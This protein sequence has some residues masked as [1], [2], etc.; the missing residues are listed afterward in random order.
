M[1][2]HCLTD[3]ECGQK[4]SNGIQAMNKKI[5]TIPITLCLFAMAFT[6]FLCF[7]VDSYVRSARVQCGNVG[8]SYDSENGVCAVRKKIP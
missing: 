7:Y 6:T 5:A 4:T 3:Q 8:M 2:E 1:C